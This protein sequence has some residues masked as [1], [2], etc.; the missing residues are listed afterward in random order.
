MSEHKPADEGFEAR[1]ARLEEITRALEEG[2]LTLERSMALFE[3]GVTL[4]RR[5]E[6]Q[7]GAAEMKVEQLLQ[8]ADGG[9]DVV[10]FDAGTNGDAPGEDG[11]W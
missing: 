5:L 7:L 3:E 8:R 9:E 10:P 11:P 1:M 2:D 6:E 4:A